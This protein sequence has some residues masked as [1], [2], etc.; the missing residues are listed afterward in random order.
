MEDRI[1]WE[2]RFDLD[3]LRAVD[4]A[5]NYLDEMLRQG[6][7]RN[8]QTQALLRRHMP[9]SQT[10]LEEG[11]L[12]VV[13]GG[14]LDAYLQDE[15]DGAL[16]AIAEQ[17]FYNNMRAYE[18]WLSDAQFDLAG[19]T[20]DLRDVVVEP[21][22]T[23]QDLFGDFPYLTRLYTTLSAEEM[24]VDPLF[25]FNPDLAEVSNIRG[26]GARWE[27][28]EGKEE[29]IDPAELVLVVT[30]ADGREVRTRPYADLNSDPDPLPLQPA[31]A[32]V[33]RMAESGQPELIFRATNIELD[34]EAA[35]LPTRL[36]LL[37]NFPNPFNSGTVLPFLIADSE[38]EGSLF[39]M[40]I[41]NVLGQPVRTVF[42]G[43]LRAGY[44]SV[45]WDGLD[46]EGRSAPSGAYFYQ[47]QNR[48]E[49]SFL[50]VRKLIVLR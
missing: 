31:A 8:A 46:E 7:P 44:G 30:L 12:Q 42:E 21:L 17:S 37:P 48:S 50:A 19:L 13:Y 9:M 22:R 47:L 11:V 35:E 3:Q 23:A 2:N 36:S 38:P 15:E 29:E 41:F 27:C 14:N 39:S 32:V 40:R 16:L 49:P 25:S 45:E 10:V 34:L 4:V 6:F 24:T 28:P 43:A 5:E 18:E 26:A 1:Y 20:D 33:E